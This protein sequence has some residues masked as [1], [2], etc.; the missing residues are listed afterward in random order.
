MFYSILFFVFIGI[1]NLPTAKY[2]VIKGKSFLINKIQI[3]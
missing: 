3:I 1:K 2:K